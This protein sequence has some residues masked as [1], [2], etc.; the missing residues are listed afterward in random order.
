MHKLLS[1]SFKK[2]I[3]LA[4]SFLSFSAYSAQSNVAENNLD[5]ASAG[6][7]AV[8]CSSLLIFFVILLGVGIFIAVLRWSKLKRNLKLGASCSLAGCFFGLIP[9]LL[10]F[11]ITSWLAY[12]GA[13]SAAPGKKASP[14]PVS[15]AS[16][17]SL[18]VENAPIEAPSESASFEKKLY[19]GKVEPSSSEKKIECTSN[20]SV[21]VPAGALKQKRELTVTK[22][23][24]IKG[25]PKAA[26][27]L[28][29]YDISLGNLKIP[30][31]AL[32][33]KI[34]IPDSTPPKATLIGAYRDHERAEWITVPLERAAPNQVIL[35]ASHFCLFVV[36]D[37]SS[38]LYHKKET[39]HFIIYSEKTM[40]CPRLINNQF[41]LMDKKGYTDTSKPS[42]GRY[43]DYAKIK[44]F[45]DITAL[46]MEKI[47]GAYSRAGFKMPAKTEVYLY[48]ARN[49]ND[50]PRFSSFTGQIY[51]PANLS[52][53]EAFCFE[54]AHEY[55]HKI[56]NQYMNVLK[57]SRWR[58]FIEACADYA[59]GR[60]AWNNNSGKI[61]DQ[62]I[63]YLMIIRSMGQGITRDYIRRPLDYFSEAHKS[64][65]AYSQ[66][67][68]QTAWFLDYMI[69]NCPGAGGFKSIWTR[70][71]K[72]AG[73]SSSLTPLKA[74]AG[75][76]PGLEK[77]YKEFAAFLILSAQSPAHLYTV[78]KE[79]LGI[80]ETIKKINVEK[81]NDFKM[82]SPYTGDYYGYRADAAQ[83]KKSVQMLK[84]SA[85]LPQGSAADLYKLSFK[86][87]T[88]I[89]TEKNPVPLAR[90][91]P[92]NGE[93]SFICEANRK[94]AYYLVATTG[95][96]PVTFK[97]KA[98][99]INPEI[100]V[101]IESSLNGKYTFTAKSEGEIKA[102]APRYEWL[103][104]NGRRKRKGARVTHKY[105]SPGRYK[106]ELKVLDKKQSLILQR[107]LIVNVA[108]LNVSVVDAKAGS[109][110][111][112]AEI[113]VKNSNGKLIRKKARSGSVSILGIPAGKYN[114][115]VRARKYVQKNTARQ[116]LVT[117]ERQ[118]QYNIKVPLEPKLKT[119]EPNAKKE[120]TAKKQYR[121]TRQPEKKAVSGKSVK[122]LLK[123]REAEL[124]KLSDEVLQVYYDSTSGTSTEY[125]YIPSRSN[126]YFKKGEF[127]NI[128]WKT[129][130]GFKFSAGSSKRPDGKVYA[131]HYDK[132]WKHWNEELEKADPDF[133]NKHRY[134]QDGQI[135]PF[136]P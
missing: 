42:P 48:E 98:S 58:W 114:M 74:S 36:I 131:N 107:K 17:K 65:D 104:E 106:L 45:I 93:N 10:I 6:I 54:S 113:A 62:K 26:K 60:V 37:M 123:I 126:K 86:N 38:M 89:L 21:I 32:K 20:V 24:N 129:R 44:F 56:Q 59:A 118:L 111:R 28:A 33:I 9:V 66:H 18:E 130:N 43:T 125:K 49:F 29:A 76:G 22:L 78:P 46:V 117:P 13:E 79:K 109:P 112:G 128:R 100:N 135:I 72:K 61:M 81:S 120:K 75:G 39:S 87:Y 68:Y 12:I 4:L 25:L 77:L 7:I 90:L 136:T 102:K 34:N 119:K 52:S 50:S 91:L 11:T 132:R 19:S 1:K 124:G 14:I 57:M 82:K 55:F 35:T 51:I 71:A 110:I 15:T 3:F 40:N 116:F 133:W 80:P 101:K 63:N 115:S 94:E 67:Q 97:V 108:S 5:K 127:R 121:A 41:K 99:V 23:G 31:K 83:D 84:I 92:Q 8:L 27:I 105:S 73:W 88:P 64:K 30:E 122:Q 70:F 96:S 85:D 69:K 134:S 16:Q 2:Y 95:D 53:L 47:Y 103:F